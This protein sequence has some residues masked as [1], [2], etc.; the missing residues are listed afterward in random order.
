MDKR[1]GGSMVCFPY[2][3]GP[4]F[5]QTFVII[6]TAQVLLIKLMMALFYSVPVRV[7]GRQHA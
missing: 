6:G 7:T 3:N 4:F 5:Q 2:P 1:H